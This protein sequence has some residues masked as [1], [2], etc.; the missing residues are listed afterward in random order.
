MAGLIKRLPVAVLTAICTLFA[1]L[2]AQN[3]TPDLTQKIPVDPQVTVGQFDNGLRYY[4]RVNKK[5]EK[6]ADLWLIVD[7]GSVF[8]DDD[9]QGLAHLAEHMAFNGTKNFRKQELIDYLEAIGMKFGP[10]VNAFTGFDETGYMLQVPTDSSHFVEK[11]FQILEDWAHQVSYDSDE[12]DKERG[13][14]I[15]EWR[16]SRGASM[17]MLDRQLP[18]LF[19]DSKYAVRLPIG[20][21]EII[22]KCDYETLRKFYRDW[23]RPDLQAIVA[24]GDFDPAYIKGLIEKHFKNL[25][26][27]K[28]ERR[29]ELYPVPDHQEPLYAIASDPEADGTSISVY[30]KRENENRET[31]ADLRGMFMEQIYNSILNNRLDELRQ[32]ADPPFMFGYSDKGSFVRTKSVYFLGARVKEDGIERGLDALLTESARI[33]K[34]G[35]TESELS[36]AKTDLLR[37]LERANE[38]RDKTQSRQYA[39]EYMRNFLE[40]EP[41]PGIENEF[42]FA[43]SLIPTIRVD[44]INALVNQYIT[45]SNR[46]IMVSMPEKEGVHVPTEAELA[47]VFQKAAARDIQAYEDK[48]SDEPLVA[49]PPQPGTIAAESRIEEL[50]L[51]EWTLSNGIRVRLKPTDFK[52]DEILFD[53]FSWGGTSLGE[54]KD[55]WSINMAASIVRMSGIGNFDRIQL[56]KKLTGKVAGVYTSLGQL[57]D[58]VSGN[59]SP[60]DM[61]TMFQLIYL[62]CTA[63]RRDEAA[64]EA[65][66][67]QM[68]GVI[69]NRS[70][71]PENV[72]SDTV[73][74]VMGSHHPRSMP[75]TLE[76]LGE[77]DLDRALEFYRDRFAD[78]GDF[79]FVFVGNFTLDSIKPL[80]LTYLG[81]LP[82]LKR[83]ETFRNIHMNPP[84][85]VQTK[86]VERG[87]EPKAQVRL[88]FTG[89]YE[90]SPE[91]EYAFYSL[92][93]VLDIKL[94]EVIREEKSGTYGIGVQPSSSRFPEQR[95]TFTINWGCDPQ[96]VDEL[97]ST[98]FLTLDSLK[99]TGPDELHITKV[100]ETQLR[101]YEVDLK[102]NR[103]WQDELRSS[104]YDNLDPRRILGRKEE[105]ATLSRDM[106]RDAAKKYL[107]NQSYVKFILLPEKK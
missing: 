106:I 25:P 97:V 50:G 76:R 43:R 20:K 49:N 65:L 40:K 52:N 64:F 15:E 9:Q 56:Q 21:K 74:V 75:W 61:E 107:N 5:P 54:D 12:I 79:M 95:Y 103:F 34:F 7:A 93:E 100:R 33:R 87:M 80:I 69:E 8:E 53:G 68:K 11:G 2:A 84:A 104:F 94:R 1:S 66:K 78:C 101:S 18:I 42:E 63:P 83:G 14:V 70:A 4:I 6:R 77:I 88:V 55:W 32:Q 71:R 81:G 82:N 24:V 105:V 23:Y 60:K 45:D 41:I 51:T 13:V 3:E 36:R 28:D 98:V 46:V 72:F 102:E 37:G 30:F 67:A 35:V 99:N 85:G 19:K 86:T 26:A 96:R 57:T 44:E 62:Y 73:S 10:E 91:N 59:C 48:V 17:R 47:A 27:R 29:K 31:L 22:E 16:L 39:M 38:E 58:G 92:G 89:P 90:W